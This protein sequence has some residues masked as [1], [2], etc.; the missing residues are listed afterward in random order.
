M[1][2]TIKNQ[3]DDKTESTNRLLKVI[4]GLLIRQGTE[5]AAPLKRQIEILS[6]LGLRPVEIAEALGRTPT[7]INK[8]LT[9]IRKIRKKNG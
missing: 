6:S 3:E 9:G 4:I 5:E 2:K 7:Y 1:K 8:E